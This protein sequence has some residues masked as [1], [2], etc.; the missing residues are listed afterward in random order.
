LVLSQ[1]TV[2]P[3][4]ANPCYSVN[5]SPC[6][7][8]DHVCLKSTSAT[9]KAGCEHVCINKSSNT[10]EQSLAFERC[11]SPC[12]TRNYLCTSSQECTFK[13]NCYSCSEKCDLSLCFAQ[14]CAVDSKGKDVLLKFRLMLFV[15]III[16]MVAQLNGIYLVK[17]FVIIS[18]IVLFV[19]VVALMELL[20]MLIHIL[21]VICVILVNLVVLYSDALQIV[22][23]VINL[24]KMVAKLANVILALLN[25]IANYIVLMD[26]NMTQTL[27]ADFVSVQI[28]YAHYMIAWSQIVNL[29]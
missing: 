20:M 12:D 3:T 21:G 26:I 23:M 9:V 10:D 28:L 19:I 18:E 4:C 14:P 1:G 17:E 8:V 2:S 22:Y 11:A 25:H 6:K 15:L 13:D 16:V 5:T 27:N 7:D 29:D 24:T